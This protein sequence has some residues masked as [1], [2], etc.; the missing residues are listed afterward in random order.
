MLVAKLDPI[1]DVMSPSWTFPSTSVAQKKTQ[2][3]FDFGQMSCI[4]MIVIHWSLNTI[5]KWRYTSMDSLSINI[6]TSTQHL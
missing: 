6:T 2:Q 5:E 3:K 4:T 1:L